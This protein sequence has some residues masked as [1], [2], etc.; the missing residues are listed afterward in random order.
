MEQHL[1]HATTIRRW[2]K[3]YFGLSEW[4]S[5]PE[6]SEQSETE[7][8]YWLGYARAV[9]GMDALYVDNASFGLVDTRT[10]RGCDKKVSNGFLSYCFDHSTS[11]CNFDYQPRESN[12]WFVFDETNQKHFARI[13]R[14]KI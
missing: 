1:L 8:E 11:C 12:G 2:E 14:R 7:Q 6:E 10:V 13:D 3:I 9:D 4:K 5:F